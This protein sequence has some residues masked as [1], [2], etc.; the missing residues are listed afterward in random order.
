[1]VCEILVAFKFLIVFIIM[2]WPLPT[3]THAHTKQWKETKHTHTQNLSKL[4]KYLNI[5]AK[6][7]DKI[8]VIV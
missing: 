4:F 8:E 1:M 5:G 6:V 2:N 3:C 7:S